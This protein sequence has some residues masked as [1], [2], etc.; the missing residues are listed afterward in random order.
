MQS[1][2]KIILFGAGSCG[3]Q[4]AQE[5][6]EDI[7]CFVDN[8]PAKQG[9]ELLGR[10]VIAAEQIKAWNYDAIVIASVYESEIRRQL[11]KMGLGDKIS[12]H[13]NKDGFGGLVPVNFNVF[14]CSPEKVAEDAKYALNVALGYV[15]KLPGGRDAI[16][17]KHILELGPGINFGTALCLLAWGAQ[18][19]TLCDRFLAQYDEHYHDQV[20]LVLESL[21]DASADLSVLQQVVRSQS[22]QVN[23]LV[24]VQSPLEEL[25]S[26]FPGH[27]AIT[28]SNA[29]FE[30]LY[31]P[32]GAFESLFDCMAVGGIGSHQV[33]FRDHRDF[34]RPLEFLLYD[35]LSF[36]ALMH[37]ACCEFGNRVRPF[38]M[39]A[40]FEDAGFTIL[41]LDENMLAADD[42]LTEFLP[43]LK[44]K[45][46]SSY[47]LMSEE[48]LKT[49]SAHFLIQ[50]R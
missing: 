29:V 27:F 35:E 24:C 32:A 8:D 31:H 46:T 34:T 33:D 43:R 21:L 7:L 2:R 23:G 39:K 10:P 28:L 13:V 38:Q 3:Q 41:D 37:D 45:K 22:H 12:S 42:Y 4:Q 44:Q 50:K 15:S 20:Y 26:L 40:M 36:Y 9:S 14:D 30:H 48:Q 17:N 11:V 19:V 5:I 25:S 18:S 49:I 16:L 1:K 47:Y 6:N